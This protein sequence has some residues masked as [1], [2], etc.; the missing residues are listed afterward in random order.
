[1]KI[2]TLAVLGCLLAVVLSA[3]P[4][5]RAADNEFPILDTFSISNDGDVSPGET[6]SMDYHILEP[7]GSG[8]VQVSFYFTS[9]VGMEVELSASGDI[10]NGPAEM[11]VPEFAAAGEY[12]LD[13]VWI[14]D[15]DGN[16]ARYFSS[17]E[18]IAT[19]GG[20]VGPDTHGFDFST[21]VF[22]VV[23][24]DEDITAPVLSSF[25]VNSPGP[26]APGETVAVDFT[27]NDGGSGLLAVVFF[28]EDV[29]GR[30]QQV[31]TDDADVALGTA[32]GLVEETWSPGTY[33]LK[34][35]LLIDLAFNQASYHA[36]GTIVL[37]S[38]GAPG[39][40]THGFDFSTAIFSVDNPAGDV[41]T[42]VLTSIDLPGGLVYFPGS[43]LVADYVASDP[44][45]VRLVL[46]DWIDPGLQVYQA[47]VFGQP[48][49]DGPA[50]IHVGSN[51]PSGVLTLD[52]VMVTDSTQL[53]VIY[54][55]DG[56]VEADP[57]GATVPGPTH[58]FDLE[59][60]DVTI[61]TSAADATC[62]GS[63][64]IAD[65]LSIR[66]IEAG[67]EAPAAPCSGDVDG[68]STTTAADALLVL[69]ILA[70]L[71]NDVPVGPVTQ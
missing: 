21:V 10:E 33:T 50:V 12:V 18:I 48:A 32:S 61:V 40:G 37:E 23:N 9:P 30:E 45:G 54:N 46:F 71:E 41:A 42:P 62:D 65:V 28:F 13:W 7:G 47:I 17:G 11:V 15:A 31:R 70:G 16:V 69:R 43:D 24:P 52:R 57:P 1:M 59:D 58:S 38:A 39:Q 4:A 66:R 20:S 36:D 29:I 63:V 14:E 44:S 67:L 55:R 53:T 19:P 2:A 68:D 60:F 26:F 3:S 34:E 51:W 35:V 49:E 22:T 27:A 64:G 25:S 8:L 5:A 6:V 56:T